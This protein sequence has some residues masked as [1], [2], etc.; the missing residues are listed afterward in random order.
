MLNFSPNHGG[1]SFVGCFGLIAELFTHLLLG[2]KGPLC[3]DLHDEH[4]FCSQAADTS[5][6]VSLTNAGRSY[7]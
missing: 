4:I 7:C 3:I 1:F 2:L 6:V 5:V